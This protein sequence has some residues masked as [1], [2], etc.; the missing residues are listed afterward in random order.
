[1]KNNI[2][3]G[4]IWTFTDSSS[5]SREALILSVHDD[6]YA[7]YVL[8]HPFRKGPVRFEV[9]GMGGVMYCDPRKVTFKH[10]DSFTGLSRGVSVDKLAEMRLKA[11]EGIGFMDA[12]G[13]GLLQQLK[14]SQAS[15]ASMGE[16]IKELTIYKTLYEQFLK[17][18]CLAMQGQAKQDTTPAH[19]AG[20]AAEEAPK[21]APPRPLTQLERN[22]MK[23]LPVQRYIAVK[24]NEVGMSLAT[25]DRLTGHVTK[26][27]PTGVVSHWAKGD[28]EANWF[29]LERIFPGLKAEAEAW[30][31][32]QKEAAQ[33]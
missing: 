24:C 3:P 8:L 10:T 26:A 27:G 9:M 5:Q 17:S 11:A 33:K 19:G 29:Q 16:K 25:L 20:K 7:E 18:V 2:K 13:D 4:E 14:S 6:G 12:G 30:A 1:M 28:S 15:V 22:R 21:G 32:K 23:Y 31:E